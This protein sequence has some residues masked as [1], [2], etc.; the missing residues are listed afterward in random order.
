MNTAFDKRA[1]A[2]GIALGAALLASLAALPAQA[3]ILIFDQ[4]RSTAAGNPVVP[5]ISAASRSRGRPAT[6]AS[7]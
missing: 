4:M 2:H 1:P 3:T 7:H 6:A 5:T